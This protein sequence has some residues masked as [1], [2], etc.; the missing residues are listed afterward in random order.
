MKYL[1][2]LYTCN[3]QSILPPEQWTCW[4]C[5]EDSKKLLKNS[6]N[7]Y[8]TLLSYRSIPLHWC[9]RSPAEL[10]IGRRIRLDLPQSTQSLTSQ[11]PYPMIHRFGSLQRAGL[12]NLQTHLSNTCI[13][14]TTDS[15]RRYLPQSTPAQCQAQC[16]SKCT[17]HRRLQPDTKTFLNRNYYCP[18]WESILK[19]RDVVW[20]MY[21]YYLACIVM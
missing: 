3:Q 17:N 8:L 9:E 7:P 6:V 15:P 1:L 11:W 20:N 12:L 4:T 16:P 21:T 18:F 14:F 2:P 13:S 19:N 10:L 5:C